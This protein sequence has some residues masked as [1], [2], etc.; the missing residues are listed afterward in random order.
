[1]E[2]DIDIVTI[3]SVHP[4]RPCATRSKTRMRGRA[5]TIPYSVLIETKTKRKRLHTR[6]LLETTISMPHTSSLHL[7][8]DCM[9]MYQLF[10]QLDF[11]LHTKYIIPQPH[12]LAGFGRGLVL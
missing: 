6:L 1:M 10:N 9:R 8:R 2:T 7:M 11:K 4:K 12:S 3:P 5:V